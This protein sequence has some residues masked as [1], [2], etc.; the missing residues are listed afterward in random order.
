FRALPT[1]RSR[2]LLRA[3]IDRDG[4]ARY[5]EA[6]EFATQWPDT[7]ALG[8]AREEI[9]NLSITIIDPNEPGSIEGRIVNGTGFKIMPTVRLAP[10]KHGARAI[11]ARADSTGAFM[12]DHVP[13]GAYLLSAFIDVK[14]DTLCGTYFAAGDTTHALPEPCVTLPD[15]LRLK[16]GEKRKLDPITLK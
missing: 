3:F 2:F 8:P 14:A 1:D 11:T 4:D 15:T 9:G 7:I 16:P 13:P 5:S 6:N 12:L 10:G